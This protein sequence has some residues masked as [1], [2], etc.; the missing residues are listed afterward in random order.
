MRGGEGKCKIPNECKEGREGLDGKR[1]YVP[2]S[3]DPELFIHYL[4]FLS[5]ALLPARL[6]PGS[7]VLHDTAPPKLE[8]GREVTSSPK[9]NEGLPLVAEAVSCVEVFC[10]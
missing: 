9:A 8:Y 7:C 10:G 4:D 5:R 1:T 6:H 3:W 2:L